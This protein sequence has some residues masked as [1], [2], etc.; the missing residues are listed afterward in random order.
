[1]SIR[2]Q[3]SIIVLIHKPATLKM[4][5]DFR[6]GAFMQT[7]AASIP[8]SMLESGSVIYHAKFVDVNGIR[9]RYYD[10]GHGEVLLMIH[11]SRFSPW[12]SANTWT[13]NIGG[14]AKKFRVLAPDKLCSGMTDN[15]KSL[16]DFTQ[17]A[18][19]QHIFEF[20]R[21]L[22]VKEFHVVGQSNG[23][24]TAARLALEHP[25]MC[26][27]LV[28]VDSATLG[29]PVG[30]MS[31]RRKKLFENGPAD[32]RE[33]IRFHWSKLSVNTNNI[34]D[35]YVDAAYFMAN[36]PKARKTLGLLR[37][38]GRGEEGPNPEANARTFP[39]DKAE[40][41]QWIREGK[42]TMPVLITWGA[43]DPSAILPIGIKL[44]EMISENTRRAEMHI[45][46][47]VAHFHYREIPEQWNQVVTNFIDTNT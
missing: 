5:R 43:K 31:E 44:F 34:T 36:T 9:T 39:R 10:E 4:R 16:D 19:V 38:D 11:G 25:D 18:I 22:G 27:S 26:K 8:A 7:A 13:L 40:T 41:H 47:N 12:G 17:R 29:P 35:D 46:N 21:T 30:E 33:Y 42:L 37:S 24:Y 23:G 20:I 15:P 3:A 32:L 1:M 14:L 6:G 2:A 28:I 45:F